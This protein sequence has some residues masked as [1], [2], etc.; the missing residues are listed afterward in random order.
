MLFVGRASLKSMPTSMA[1][2]DERLDFRGVVPLWLPPARRTRSRPTTP[3][4]HGFLRAEEQPG[5]APPAGLPDSNAALRLLL[6]QQ[7]AEKAAHAKRR[8]RWPAPAAPA[9]L[10]PARLRAPGE[11]GPII[12]RRVRRRCLRPW[13]HATAHRGTARHGGPE[14][15]DRA[16]PPA[17]PRPTF[18]GPRPWRGS[19]ASPPEPGCERLVGLVQCTVSMSGRPTSVGARRLRARKCAPMCSGARHAAGGGEPSGHAVLSRRP[20][21]AARPETKSQPQA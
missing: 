20:V 10:A 11:F 13:P 7:D 15:V 2:K 12:L 8:P 3:P 9:P 5:A 18:P 14:R 17:A 4:P 6:A 19:S 1:A 16:Q 21:G